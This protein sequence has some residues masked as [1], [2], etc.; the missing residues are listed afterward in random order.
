LTFTSNFYTFAPMRSQ[1]S[2]KT[3]QTKKSRSE[4][5][6]S[7][8]NPQKRK[9]PLSFRSHTHVVLRST[10]ATKIWS[11]RRHKIKVGQIL[12]MF[13]KKHHIGLVSYANVGNHLHLD[14]QISSRQQYQKFIRAVS[15]SIMMTVTGYSRWKKAPSGFQFWDARPFSRIVTS[16]REVLNL[17]AY[18]RKNQ[19]EGYGTPT[20]FARYLAKQGWAPRPEG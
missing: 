7:Y 20:E 17:K 13:A 11:F 2:F 9:R 8:K 14:L 5:G 4:H 12:Q 6:G 15:A 18:I 10:K 16:W 19:W 3:T 1:F